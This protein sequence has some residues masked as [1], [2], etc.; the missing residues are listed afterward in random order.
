MGQVVNEFS[1]PCLE[2]VQPLE[3]WPPGEPQCT[4]QHEDDAMSSCKLYN[5]SAKSQLAH[6]LTPRYKI[7][8]TA[9]FIWAGILVG[10]ASGLVSSQHWCTLREICTV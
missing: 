5:T 4:S 3:S 7:K 8:A 1:L 2:P 9:T 10:P 6:L